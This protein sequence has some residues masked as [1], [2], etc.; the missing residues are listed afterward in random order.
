MIKQSGMKLLMSMNKNRQ[1]TMRIKWQNPWINKASK[2]NQ[3]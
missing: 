2:G 3:A 1:Q